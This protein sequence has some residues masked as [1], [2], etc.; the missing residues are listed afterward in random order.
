MKIKK[1]AKFLS[2]SYLALLIFLPSCV[3]GTEKSMVVIIP[4]YNNEKWVE[5]NLSS[6]L[7]QKYENFRVI[8]IDDCSSDKTYE[9]ARNIVEKLGQQH[10]VTIIH[11]LERCGAMANWYTAIHSCDD[12]E[13]IVSVDGDDWLPHDQVLSYL[14]KI[15]TE[16]D[17]WLTYGQFIE[18]PSNVIDTVYSKPFSD[19]VIKNNLFRKVEQLPM[20]HLRTFYAWLF[21]SIK[22]QD[23]LY[24]EDFY[25]MS[26]DKVMLAPMIEM[27]GYRHFR[28]PE[29]L[30]VY[31]NHNPISDHRVD[32][33]RQHSL[34]WYVLSMPA[35]QRLDTPIEYAYD[36]Q[37][38]TV[39]LII[40]AT[41]NLDE[42]SIRRIDSL[43][44]QYQSV[45]VFHQGNF[46][47]DSVTMSPALKLVQ[48]SESDC[49]IKLIDA[50][51][52]LKCKYI[53]ISKDFSA[54]NCE[55]IKQQALL[56]KTTQAP[57]FYLSLKYDSVG[58][59][60]FLR[61]LPRI[62]HRCYT[63]AW[64]AK[65]KNGSW[66]IP[67]FDMTLWEKGVL[68]KI[69]NELTFLNV[70]QLEEQLKNW[71]SQNNILGLMAG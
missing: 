20:S 21:K 2:Y 60:L 13:V 67:V 43:A 61:K 19:D 53:M 14:N 7:T 66:P 62:N 55:D 38:D 51:S 8:Y 63:Y 22:L 46:S 41:A 27:A 18:Y 47:C 39:S 37:Q 65:N 36:E 48:L 54:E 52:S 57:I 9:L 5:K 44:T 25:S 69:L 40:F 15:Y 35:Y 10:R 58:N 56:L 26:C 42:A 24:G 16:K 45:L 3:L 4:S 71:V 6:I 30:Y 32:Q 11:N 12:D 64:F 31:N 23:V 29:A 50:I 28:S 49:S 33:S 34:G 59:N 70:E 68:Q 17:V 1:I